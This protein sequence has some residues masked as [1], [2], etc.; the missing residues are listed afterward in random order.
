MYCVR[1]T[2]MQGQLLVNRLY[3]LPHSPMG[4]RSSKLL[5]VVPD[6]QYPSW[7]AIPPYRQIPLGTTKTIGGIKVKARTPLAA[8]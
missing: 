7:L 2:T 4:Q 8:M 6:T 5:T 3:A 1:K